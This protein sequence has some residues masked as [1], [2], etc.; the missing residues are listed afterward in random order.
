MIELDSSLSAYFYFI[1]VC[2]GLDGLLLP[3]S[4]YQLVDE[5]R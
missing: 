3:R 2:F 4:L 5:D 1:V